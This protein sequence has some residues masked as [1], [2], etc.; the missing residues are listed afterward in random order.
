VSVEKGVD[1]EWNAK[2]AQVIEDLKKDGT[3]RRISLKWLGYDSTPA[4]EATT[5]TSSQ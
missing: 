1:P 3:I 4:D 5:T 2:V